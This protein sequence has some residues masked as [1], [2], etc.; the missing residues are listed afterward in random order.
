[1]NLRSWSEN[2]AVRQ[3]GKRRKDAAQPTS[4]LSSRA[5]NDAEVVLAGTK[6]GKPRRHRP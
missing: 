5:N 2:K 3:Q 1:M 4:L 6:A